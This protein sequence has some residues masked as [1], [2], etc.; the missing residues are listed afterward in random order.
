MYFLMHSKHSCCIG[1]IYKFRYLKFIIFFFY[2]Y[3]CCL[4]SLF[5]SLLWLFAMYLKNYLKELF[6]VLHKGI[7]SRSDFHLLLPALSFW[8]HLNPGSKLKV[9]WAHS[10]DTNL[11]CQS[12]Q[13]L[14]YFQFTFTL[15]VAFCLGFHLNV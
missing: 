12:V 7:L 8:D 11:D 3:L 15:K 9:P 10:V 5:V 1:Y 13:G 4:V 14:T 6:K 2:S